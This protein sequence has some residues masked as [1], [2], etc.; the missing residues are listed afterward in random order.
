MT[1]HLATRMYERCPAYRVKPRAQGQS[2]ATILF[3]LSTGWQWSPPGERIGK[4]ANHN[5]PSSESNF[6]AL[7]DIH[8][9]TP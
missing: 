5:L 4:N 7:L 8:N 6:G 1:N 2:Y 9:F 3:C